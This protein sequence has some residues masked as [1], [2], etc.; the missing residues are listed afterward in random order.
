MKLTASQ[1][2]VRYLINEGIPYVLGI[3]G[4]GNVQFGEALK[5][6]ENKIRYIQLKNEQN[7]VHIATGYA[8]MTGRPL[9]V[10]T[11]IGPGTTNLVTGA[12][13]ARVNRLPV[14][15]LPGDAF[16]D[17]TGPLLQQ[18]EGN[19]V[20]DEMASDALT[21]V[22]KYWVRIT[23]PEQLMKRLPEAFDAM[24]EPGEQGPAVLCLPMDLQAMAYDYDLKTLL[25]PR[26]SQWERIAPDQRAVKR[27]VDALI[28]AKRPLIIAGGGVIRSKA[29]SEVVKLAELAVIP[30]VSTHAGNGTMLFNHP[31]NAYTVG[32]DGSLC[33]NNIAE[34]ADLVIGIGTRYTDFTTRSETLFGR[35]VQF[36]NINIC[37]FDLSKERAI[38]LW[39]DAQTTLKILLRQLRGK[40]SY[41]QKLRKSY[42]N[43]VQVHREKW[44]KIV[45]EVTNE[46]SYPMTQARIIGILNDFTDRRAVVVSAAGSLPGHLLRF[47]KTKDPTRLGYHLEYGFSTMGYEISGGI[48]VKLADPTRN[49]Y[50]I[51]GDATFLMQPQE[52]VT[53]VQEKIAITILVIDNGGNQV[54]RGLQVGSGF[55]EF[56]NEFKFRKGKSL[57]GKY[58]PIDFVKIAQGMGAHAFFADRPETVKHALEKAQKIKN[59]PVV[60]HIKVEPGRKFPPGYNSWW[61][62]PRPE[63][64][65][66]REMQKHLK[67]YKKRKATQVIR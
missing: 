67:V 14:L 62:V 7:G 1:V 16:V 63:V 26:D 17:A 18:I 20:A 51:I 66:R 22:S 11:S 52:I 30:V 56:A 35:D 5:E 31:L 6:A 61:D 50:V 49:V 3:L 9:A 27:T 54:I 47:W 12:A 25:K 23:R 28:R 53:A 46:E 60:I 44:I 39:G 64:S 8:K 21:P 57:E 65:S 43:S 33:G 19:K 34:K 42:F 32:P 58:L 15:L 24:F 40:K 4:H 10:T 55:S 36:I 59:V 45:E 29:W 38:K 41:F 2:I 37:P 13:A 48:G